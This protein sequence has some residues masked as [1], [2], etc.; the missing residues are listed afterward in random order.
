MWVKGTTKIGRQADDQIDYTFTIMEAR[1]LN[2][3]ERNYKYGKRK[4]LEQMLWC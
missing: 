4:K 2:V 1:F 3:G